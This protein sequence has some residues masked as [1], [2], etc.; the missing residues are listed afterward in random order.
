MQPSRT[1]DGRA[2]AGGRSHCVRSRRKIGLLSPREFSRAHPRV[3]T[4]PNVSRTDWRKR[5]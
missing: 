2:S 5:W 4:E 1:P 3:S